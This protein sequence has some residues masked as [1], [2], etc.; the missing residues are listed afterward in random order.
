MKANIV[1][2]SALAIAAIALAVGGAAVSPAAAK[3]GMVH[4]AGINSCK[5]QS[6]C[7]TASNDCKGQNSCKGH[8]WLPVKSAKSC[9][10]KGGTV[11]KI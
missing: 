9:V 7:K 10:A 4:C 5:G 1:S 6:A 11:V 3:G 8:G 2:G